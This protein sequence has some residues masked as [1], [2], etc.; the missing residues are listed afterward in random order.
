M[1]YV[2]LIAVTSTLLLG[3]CG[4]GSSS[5]GSGEDKEANNCVRLTGN[6]NNTTTV[7]NSCGN[8]IYVRFFGNETAAFVVLANTSVTVN[9]SDTSGRFGA[10]DA[11]YKPRTGDESGTFFCEK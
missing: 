1:K 11:P 8:D 4:G 5:G 9:T 3:A 7:T 10:C 2:K 6:G